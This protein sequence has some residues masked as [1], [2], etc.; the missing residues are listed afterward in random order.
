M[1]E[2]YPHK[3]CISARE[4][5]T[6]KYPANKGTYAHFPGTK[7]QGGNATGY[8]SCHAFQQGS[9]PGDALDHRALENAE[10]QPNTRD[11]PRVGSASEERFR[12]SNSLA[13]HLF[14]A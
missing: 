12:C 9:G 1:R 7:F 6:C 5:K 4:S 11:K 10:T 2:N 13:F 8:V 3:L 14:N